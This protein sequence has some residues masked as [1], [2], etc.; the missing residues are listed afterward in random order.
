MAG[1]RP[2]LLGPFAILE[3]IKGAWDIPSPGS[4]STSPCCI[5]TSGV[6]R[7]G[8]SPRRHTAFVGEAQGCVEGHRDLGGLRLVEQ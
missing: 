2:R 6:C 3:R 5:Q 7:E 4:R 1:E 8:G